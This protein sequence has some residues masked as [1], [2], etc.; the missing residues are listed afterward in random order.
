MQ[1]WAKMEYNCII[2][3]GSAWHTWWNL[4]DFCLLLWSTKKISNHPFH[5]SIF[6]LSSLIGVMF[7]LCSCRK[8]TGVGTEPQPPVSHP[9]TAE[10][11]DHCA[12]FCPS[13][14]WHMTSLP[15][16]GSG[17]TLLSHIIKRI[18]FIP[19]LYKRG[20][21]SGYMYLDYYIKWYSTSFTFQQSSMEEPNEQN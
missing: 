5:F 4:F 17:H 2:T 20:S 11:A 1:H 21:T 19:Y 7:S 12:L 14:P 6:E 16:S 10:S 8:V 3:P 9:G 13:L 15:S 18:L